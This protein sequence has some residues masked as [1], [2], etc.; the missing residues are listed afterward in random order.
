V[1]PLHPPGPADDERGAS[2][3]NGSH[4]DDDDSRRGSRL[5]LLYGDCGLLME[6]H[7]NY[8]IDP[9]TGAHATCLEMHAGG[10]LAYRCLGEL[11]GRLGQ[12]VHLMDNANRV[13]HVGV[14]GSA[15]LVRAEMCHA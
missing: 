4:D 2:S 15:P 9:R 14:C 7:E 5:E 11:S 6:S 8:T 13:T 10:R 1:A 3:S 12:R